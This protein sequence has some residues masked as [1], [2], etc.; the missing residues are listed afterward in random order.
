MALD[1]T[2]CMFAEAST[3]E[4]GASGSES[5]DQ[6]GVELRTRRWY[7]YNSTPGWAV[8]FRLDDPA[9]AE[10][11]AQFM[12]RIVTNGY[13]GYDQ[14][15]RGTL[16]T[17]L[18][19]VGYDPSAVHIPCETDC[20]MTAYEAVKFAT[21][22]ECPLNYDN[23]I[24]PDTGLCKTRDAATGLCGETYF[25]SSQTYPTGMNFHYYMTRVLPL[26]GIKVSA[27][28][29]GGKDESGGAEALR[30]G[31][32]PRPLY[33]CVWRKSN[34]SFS[35]VKY[36]GRRFSYSFT[37]WRNC[38]YESPYERIGITQA[39]IDASGG[40]IP[41][42]TETVNGV[43]Y[44]NELGRAEY[45]FENDCSESYTPPADFT[46]VDGN[47]NTIMDKNGNAVTLGWERTCAY[48]ALTYEQIGLLEQNLTISKDDSNNAKY[49][50]AGGAD[51]PPNLKRGDVVLSLVTYSSTKSLYPVTL[52]DGTTARASMYSSAG[53]I[54]VW[55]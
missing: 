41:G 14:S 44:Y 18:K 47:G 45:L 30:S 4:D 12:E 49:L 22:I 11:T 36:N 24:N 5:G 39:L 28:I 7:K 3:G 50:L 34:N 20:S 42:Y 17:R 32:H 1:K 13:V 19:Q 38:Y 16:E 55:I 9:L 25:G 21:G 54:A 15:G 31:F 48:N 23:T 43:N 29:I 40:E 53:H 52:E 27:F 10:R 33:H 35:Y 8:V 26:N 37:G 46:S 2:L 6:L 51:Y